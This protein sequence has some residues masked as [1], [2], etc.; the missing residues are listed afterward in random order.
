[1]HRRFR[2][3]RLIFELLGDGPLAAAAFEEIPAQM[4]SSDD[5]PADVIFEFGKITV[6]GGN[7]VH[8]G[9]YIVGRNWILVRDRYVPHL[10]VQD[11]DIMRVT[12]D[13]R[14]G[15]L[16]APVVRQLIRPM[17]YAFNDSWRRLSKRFYYLVF[18][19]A[20]ELHQIRKGQTFCHASACTD[21][22]RTVLLMAWGG[23][24]KTSSLI[25]LL[26]SADAWRFISDDLA[27]L[28]D[29]G[30]IHRTPLKMQVYPY[31]LEG[32]SRLSRALM[33]D[34]SLIDRAQWASRQRVL[35]KKSVRRRVHAETLFGEGKGAAS[36]PL[37]H[38]LFLRRT[39]VEQFAGHP[40]SAGD[41]AVQ[42]AHVMQFELQ[43]LWSMLAAAGSAGPASEGFGFG[44]DSP[45]ATRMVKDIVERGL[46]GLR[47]PPML[48]DVPLGA[49]PA[50]L[51]T[52]VTGQID[53]M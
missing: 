37:T 24:G 31:N 3:G 1:M 43:M 25:R 40:L 33:K 17:D 6:P 50:D 28:D 32:E 42:M 53:R 48:L 21:G 39:E 7:G 46:Q 38:V 30:V 9:Q 12:V 4:A 27:V 29:A 34:R 47:A 14:L 35:G 19:Q 11:G 49:K 23:I 18:N 10:I 8:L 51:L 5:A 20:I 36:A 15:M 16:G 45:A 2:L 26:H 44:I 52:A 22:E 41:A 13:S